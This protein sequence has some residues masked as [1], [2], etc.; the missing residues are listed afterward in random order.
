MHG[1]VER[2]SACYGVVQIYAIY[3]QNVYM[4]IGDQKGDNYITVQNH[5]REMII[6]MATFPQ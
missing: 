2:Y 5:H 6:A 4:Y 3:H 1:S